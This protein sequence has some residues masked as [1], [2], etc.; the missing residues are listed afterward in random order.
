MVVE[1]C[2]PVVAGCDAPRPHDLGDRAP[3]RP[4]GCDV[5]R[6]TGVALFDIADAH[7]H[8]LDERFPDRLIVGTSRKRGEGRPYDCSSLPWRAHTTCGPFT[9]SHIGNISR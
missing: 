7:P 5:R 3:H 6:G 9:S 4:A 1:G 2:E 8:D